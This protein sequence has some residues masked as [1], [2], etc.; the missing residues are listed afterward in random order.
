MNSNIQLIQSEIENALGLK[1]NISNKKNNS[2]KITIKII[3]DLDQFEMISNYLEVVASL[4]IDNNKF[5]IN[6][7]FLINELVLI[8]FSASP[9]SGDIL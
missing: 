7:S 8:N 5:F 6:K 9:L 2:G 3:K 1:I 4:Q